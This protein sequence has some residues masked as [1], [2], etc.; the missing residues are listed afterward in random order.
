MRE[1]CLYC[2][3]CVFFSLSMLFFTFVC[4]VILRC[5]LLYLRFANVIFNFIFL[6]ITS[7]ITAVVIVIVVVG[8]QLQ[9]FCLAYHCSTIFLRLLCLNILT[10]THRMC[11]YKFIFVCLLVCLLSPFSPRPPHYHFTI[12]SQSINLCIIKI[13]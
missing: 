13:I 10:Y 9:L 5:L 8:L 12:L 2:C 6:I 4:F 7:I 1:S 3:Q 11:S